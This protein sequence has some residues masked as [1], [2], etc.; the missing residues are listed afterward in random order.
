[1][2][3]TTCCGVRPLVDPPSAPPELEPP[4]PE[5]EELPLDEE[6]EELLLE[7]LLLEELEEPEEVEPD[8][9]PAPE[10]LPLEE[11]VEVPEE[12]P[13]EPPLEEELEVPEEL[14][15][16]DEPLP[17]PEELA[18]PPS[19]SCGPPPEEVEPHAV[20]PSEAQTNPHQMLRR[21]VTSLENSTRTAVAPDFP[22]NRQREARPLPGS[23]EPSEETLQKSKH[24]CVGLCFANEAARDGSASR[25]CCL[26]RR[27]GA[28]AYVDL[29]ADL[30]GRHG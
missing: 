23:R 20:M 13:L 8:E 11:E 26:V 6:L 7:E 29:P 30:V 14:P 3:L 24:C 15:L 27:P 9:L 17:D 16:P 2:T 19:V 18:V 1:M 22:G 12:L 10:E 21:M 5:L 28:G 4:L 25:R